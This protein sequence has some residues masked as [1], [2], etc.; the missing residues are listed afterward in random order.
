MLNYVKVS[1]SNCESNPLANLAKG[2]LPAM[3]IVALAN[4][5]YLY[6]HDHQEI[7][8]EE[9]IKK[10]KKKM[11]IEGFHRCYASLATVS[12]DFYHSSIKSNIYRYIYILAST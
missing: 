1:R 11:I 12:L 9:K 3:V 10:G 7:I 5:L 8:K 4:R 2:F 6:D